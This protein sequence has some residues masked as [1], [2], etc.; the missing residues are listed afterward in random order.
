VR[1]ADIHE[2]FVILGCALIYLSQIRRF[3]VLRL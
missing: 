3:G 1:R 2:V